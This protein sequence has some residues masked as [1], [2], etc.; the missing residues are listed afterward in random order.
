[1]PSLLKPTQDA[2]ELV[3]TQG[4]LLL[5]R[6][7]SRSLRLT[8]Y[9]E[10]T[11][12]EDARKGYL[13]RV[14]A[15]K[16]PTGDDQRHEDALNSWRA[17]LS[18]TARPEHQLHAKLEARLLI[19]MGGTVL[20]N[21]GLQLDRFGTAFIPGSAVKACARRTALAALRQ[22]CKTGAKPEGD[23][24]LFSV[25][26]TC[27]TPGDLL[28]AILRVFGCTDLEWGT[29]DETGN[30]LAWACDEQWPT[31]RDAARCAL[32]AAPGCDPKDAKPTRRGTVAYLPAYPIHY[33]PAADLE[34]DVLTS[35]HPKYYSGDLAVAT[36]TENPI[37]V[38]FP[39]VTAGTIYT[40]ALLPVGQPDP[41]L[42]THAH[43]WLKTGL[44]LFGLGAKTAAGYGFFADVTE[45]T[46]Q[47]GVKANEALR[48]EAAAV[49]EKAK[50]VADLAARKAIEATRAAMT[51]EQKADAELADRAADW[52]WMKSHLTKF[53]Q[54]PPA[55]QAALLRWFAGAGK[56][57]WLGEIKSDAAKGTKPWSQIVGAIH[58]AKK[59]HKIDLP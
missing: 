59:T 43:A 55:D 22:W 39:A 58:A 42:L 49:A 13:S 50:Q 14:V 48:L 8:R 46:V 56:E 47:K 9:A 21:A 37:P 10:P 31:L 1:M 19:N 52:G 28:L 12:K 11:L 7:T 16:S 4:S 18:A 38:Y 57:R 20:E 32:N 44:E 36:D 54:H 41:M 51:P 24:A 30:D 35:H 29:Y 23:D 5:G 34:L 53:A 15:N 45:E 25:C 27:K 3:D 17:W 40:F 2:L 6:C 26:A 33:R